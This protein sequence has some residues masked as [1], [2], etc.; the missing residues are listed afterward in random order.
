M[1]LFEQIENENTDYYCQDNERR[2]ISERDAIDIATAYAEKRSSGSYSIT[3]F[4]V[5]SACT[6]IP[7]ICSVISNVVSQKQQIKRCK[8]YEP[9]LV[10]TTALFE[11]SEETLVR[12][13][14]D[15]AISGDWELWV[16]GEFCGHFGSRQDAI[17][18]LRDHFGLSITI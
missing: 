16:G 9:E 8:M 5:V 15:H 12:I 1:N 4:A 6:A 7:T 13:A 18:A 11:G 10:F 2:S 3:G 17:D 14:K